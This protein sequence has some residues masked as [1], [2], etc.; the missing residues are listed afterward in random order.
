MRIVMVFGTLKMLVL[1]LPSI[2]HVVLVRIYI[3][4]DLLNGRVS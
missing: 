4:D 3:I 2:N 1:P